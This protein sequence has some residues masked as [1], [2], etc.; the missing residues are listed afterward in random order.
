MGE[1]T[2]PALCGI[3]LSIDQGQFIAVL[4][5][6]GSGKTTLLNL[7]GGIDKPTGG[8][9]YFDTSQELSSLPEKKL[10][11]YRRN[12]VGFIFQ[13]YNLVGS[14]T[15]FENVELVARLTHEP[16]EAKKI[17][18]DLLE[19][20]DLGDISFK[21]P[22]QLSGGEQQRVSIARALAKEPKILLADEPTGSLDSITAGKILKLLQKINKEYKVTIV[23]VTHNKGIASLATKII[24]LRDG[25]IYGTALYD[26]L[27][28]KEFW[29]ELNAPPA[30]EEA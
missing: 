6:S 5:P 17:S 19:A 28:E 25:K 21:F 23:I 14:L 29:E 26:P 7:I 8:E 11:K 2:V 24:Y 15:A 27:K 22:A 3:D 20:V 18:S 30:I 16:S 9:I 13:F 4:G 10:T 1:L 12:N